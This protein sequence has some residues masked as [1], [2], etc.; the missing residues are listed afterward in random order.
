ME[1]LLG[2]TQDQSDFLVRELVEIDR[3]LRSSKSTQSLLSMNQLPKLAIEID[4]ANP[5]DKW[6]SYSKLVIEAVNGTISS[7]SY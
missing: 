7:E 6:S 1:T 2:L 3:K 4:H 5:P